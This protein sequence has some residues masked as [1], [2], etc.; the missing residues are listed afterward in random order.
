[1]LFD[2]VSLT[3]V[4]FLKDVDISP[5][6]REPI[7][8]K[9]FDLWK[10]MNGSPEAQNAIFDGKKNVYV[11]RKLKLTD[12]IKGD[13][14][15][16]VFENENES[17]R[18]CITFFWFPYPPCSTLLLFRPQKFKFTIKLAAQV[19]MERLHRYIENK[20]DNEVPRDAIQVFDVLLKHRPA[21]NFLSLS[22]KTGTYPFSSILPRCITSA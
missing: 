21:H 14:S 8:R 4:I 22:R 9:L 1:M 16:L 10:R 17:D 13:E 19:N 7:N 12:E 15:Q 18:Y 6:T 11:P 5:E 3:I 2:L 20:G